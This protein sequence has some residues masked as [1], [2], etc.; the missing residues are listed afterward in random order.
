MRRGTR[1]HRAAGVMFVL[2]VYISM[3]DAA[4]YLVRTA[5]DEAFSGAAFWIVLATL[6]VGTV[7]SV[8]F[9]VLGAIGKLPDLHQRWMLLCFAFLMAA[10]LL[11]L[12]WGVLPW[13]LP[14]LSMTDN[15]RVA[16]MHLGSVVT[17][18]A[19]LASR[20]L[21]RRGTDPGVLGT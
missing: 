5:P 21:D 4:I 20:T 2:A 9:G 19:L 6:L 8:T 11:R 15:N 7:L 3:A 14:G 12:E 17:F 16:I 10:P 1:L 18:G 13:L